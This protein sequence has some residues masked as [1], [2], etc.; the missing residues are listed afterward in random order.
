MVQSFDFAPK[1]WESG[2]GLRAIWREVPWERKI[3]GPQFLMGLDSARSRP[4]MSFAFKPGMRRVARS[5]D[6]R[7]SLAAI[8]PGM[9]CGD[10]V[11]ILDPNRNEVRSAELVAIFG[12]F[13]FDWIVRLRS[14]GTQLDQHSLFELKVPLPGNHA[15]ASL[16][17]YLNG[18]AILFARLWSAVVVD[19]S[20]PWRRLWAVTPHERLRIRCILDALVARLYGL[21][22]EDFAWILRDCDHPKNLVCSAMYARRFD[23]KGFWRVEKEVDPELRHPVLAQVAFRDLQVRGL[24][25]FLAQND[26]E[27]WMLPETVCLADFGLGHDERARLAQPVASALG[28]R[29]LPW[30]LEQSV[31]ESWEEC[32]RHA[33]IIAR[34]VPP[35]SPPVIAVSVPAPDAS[36]SP[37][38][39]ASGFPP[40]QTV[41]TG[42]PAPGQGHLFAMPPAP[43]KPSKRGKKR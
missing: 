17:V 25:A 18:A 7:T 35:P 41:L 11:S 15:L 33:E 34:I 3:I 26:G 8:I 20:L 32:R 29:F 19:R 6:T 24:D 36:T 13:S 40:I 31:E 21:S 5:T 2:T 9:P 1:A 37:H 23:P 22:E 42:P 28:P 16:C 39:V 4:R 43:R 10:K 14:G 38:A 30:Q 27:G 12:S